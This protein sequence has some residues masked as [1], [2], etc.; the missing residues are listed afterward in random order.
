MK[1]Q[2]V[3]VLKIK[4]YQKLGLIIHIINALSKVKKK[5]DL[6]SNKNV[7]ASQFI[8]YCDS[9]NHSGIWNL[10]DLKSKLLKNK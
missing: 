7:K 8:C 9:M 4:F 6:K 2:K 1:Y 5:V 10:N 3:K